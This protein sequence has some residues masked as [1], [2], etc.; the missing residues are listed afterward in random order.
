MKTVAFLFLILVPVLLVA[1][2]TLLTV[3]I[4]RTTEEKPM[5]TSNQPNTA[6][7]GNASPSKNNAVTG[8]SEDQR[9]GENV[10]EGKS[11]SA[12]EPVPNGAPVE[13]PDDQ[14]ASSVSRNEAAASANVPPPDGR[15]YSGGEEPYAYIPTYSPKERLP[16]VPLPP[17]Q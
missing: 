16:I 10:P 1:S 5:E 9:A 7:N 13:T 15:V 4:G 2:L 11:N 6:P 3:K 14:T 12:D 8:S 17:D